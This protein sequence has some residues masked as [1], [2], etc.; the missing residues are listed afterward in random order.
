[1]TGTDSCICHVDHTAPAGSCNG[2]TLKR[3]EHGDFK[4]VVGLEISLVTVK[5]LSEFSHE[6]DYVEFIISSTARIWLC[7]RTHG[8]VQ[9]IVFPSVSTQM[10]LFKIAMSIFIRENYSNCN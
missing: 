1:M 5:V 3:V 8:S 10:T 7:P 6:M 2:K 9:R 4:T